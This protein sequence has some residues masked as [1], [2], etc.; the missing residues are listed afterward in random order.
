MTH[1]KALYGYS[2]SHLAFPNEV[3]TSVAAV[4]DYLQQRDGMLELL[5]DS[6]H[7]AQERMKNFAYKKRTDKTFEVGDMVFIKLQP[8]RQSSITL[9]R[10][11]KLFACYYRPFPV[12]AKVGSVA[13]KLQLPSTSQIHLVFHVSQL[14]KRI[15]EASITAPTLPITDNNGEIILMPVAMLGTREITHGRSSVPQMII[16]WSHITAEDAT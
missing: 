8:Y 11:F 12:I 9:R 3:F 13:Y 2:P 16:K 4:E 7:K 6:L 1:F 10:N 5:K 14:K 15:G